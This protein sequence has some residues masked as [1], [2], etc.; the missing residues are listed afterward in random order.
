MLSLSSPSLILGALLLSCALSGCS[1]R[2][3]PADTARATEKAAPPAPTTKDGKRIHDAVA[4][5][6]NEAIELH[7]VHI[8]V[9]DVA[10]HAKGSCRIIIS[11][12]EIIAGDVA[13]VVSGKG[14]VDVSQSTV[15]GGRAGFAIAG[16]GHLKARAT[17]F[18]GGRSITGGG[19]F[20]DGGE[21]SWE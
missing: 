7:G 19:E 4:C 15:R 13:I 17:R 8:E 20:H 16:N 18:A 5:A 21:N 2:G 9:E 11:G 10:V 3:K 1:S 12:S 14:E 6:G